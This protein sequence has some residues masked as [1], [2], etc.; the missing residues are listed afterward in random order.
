VIWCTEKR[1]VDGVNA[2]VP[3]VHGATR[4]D[5]LSRAGTPQTVR[6]SPGSVSTCLE[7]CGCAKHACS[8]RMQLACSWHAAGMQLAC[9][10]H[11]ARMQPEAKK[12]LFGDNDQ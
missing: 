5:E 9:N 7:Q 3:V 11:A 4:N 2:H 6:N 8:A 12:R 10:S 1:P